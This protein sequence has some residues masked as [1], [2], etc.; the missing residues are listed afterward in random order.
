MHTAPHP[1]IAEPQTNPIVARIQEAQAGG[2]QPR[3]LHFTAKK[4]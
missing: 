1:I 3:L 2:H 4:T